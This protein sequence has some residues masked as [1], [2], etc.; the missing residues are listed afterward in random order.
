MYRPGGRTVIVLLGI[1]VVVLAGRWAPPPP[2]G[3][4]AAPRQTVWVERAVDGD[5][6]QLRGLGRVRVIGV[7]TPE[8]GQPGYAEATEFTRKTCAR[9]LVEIEVCP[10]RPVD[11]YDR[12]RAM[13]YYRDDAGREHSL[14]DELIRRRLGHA[15]S[16]QP[17]HIPDS[18]WYDLQ[19][20][21]P[22]GEPDGE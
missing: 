3:E 4:I 13:V 8:V 6:L 7:D 12:V 1:A 2:R 5:T 16:I 9:R 19:S 20:Q 22:P 11:R 17:C 10:V 14:A 15:L 21:R 18:H